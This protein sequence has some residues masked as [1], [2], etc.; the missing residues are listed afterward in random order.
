VK[1]VKGEQ[2]KNEKHYPGEKEVVTGGIQVGFV[3]DQE[4]DR[5]NQQVQDN[6]DGLKIREKSSKIGNE[7]REE[8][9]RKDQAKP[10]EKEVFS[11]FVENKVVADNQ[12]RKKNNRQ[13]QSDS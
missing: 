5:T 2:T 3:A 1:P 10:S 9:N 13:C 6:K 7:D 4:D 11:G 8:E 12:Q